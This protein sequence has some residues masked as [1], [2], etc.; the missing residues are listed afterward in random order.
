MLAAGADGGNVENPRRI[1]AEVCAGALVGPTVAHR[2]ACGRESLF[3]ADCV[4]V[5]LTTRLSRATTDVEFRHDDR[6]SP[7]ARGSPAADA[8]RRFVSN[9]RTLHRHS[10]LSMSS[11]L[12]NLTSP[13]L[14]SPRHASDVAVFL[15][16][17]PSRDVSS[18]LFHPE[19]PLHPPPTHRTVA[20]CPNSTVVNVRPF[21]IIAI[22]LVL[23]PYIFTCRTCVS[24][25]FWWLLSTA[26]WRE[27]ARRHSPSSSSSSSAAAS[28]GARSRSASTR[29]AP[30]DRP[31]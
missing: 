29:R 2:V 16:S 8:P 20:Y 3:G 24:R 11:N 14:S 30:P 12:N 23:G 5:L 31:P 7:S 4:N 19:R 18:S 25:P 22:G 28:F 15:S 1:T 9:R 26:S 10:T 21:P 13:S 27:Y 17:L 6:A